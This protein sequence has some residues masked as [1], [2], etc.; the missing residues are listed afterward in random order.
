ML[1]ADTLY[2]LD[3]LQIAQI[4]EHLENFSSVVVVTSSNSMFL[5][6]KLFTGIKFINAWHIYRQ[7]VFQWCLW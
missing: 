2:S 6:V 3:A 5:Q 7:Q 4:N 1:R